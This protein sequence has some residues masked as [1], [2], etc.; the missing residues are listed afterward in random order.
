VGGLALQALVFTW[1]EEHDQF[2]LVWHY[3]SLIVRKDHQAILGLL[4]LA[5]PGQLVFLSIL[6]S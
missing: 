3:F 1:L 6:V 5:D 4:L 2:R